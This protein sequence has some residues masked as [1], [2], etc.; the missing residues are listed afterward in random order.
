MLTRLGQVL[1]WAAV[2]ISAPL[3]ALG[4]GLILF[5]VNDDAR[6]FG[7]MIIIIGLLIW[8]AG[9]AAKYILSAE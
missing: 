2:A 6:I 8:C 4:S 9:R 5:G 3:V 7:G 1:Y